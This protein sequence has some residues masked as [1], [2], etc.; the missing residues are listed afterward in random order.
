LA[1]SRLRRGAVIAYHSALELH[2]SAYTEG[3]EVHVIAPGE[4]G[5]LEVAGFS[6]GF[7]KP[8]RAFTRRDGE[9][10]D[11]VTV[12][13]VRVTT[14]ERS[15]ADL[16][17]RYELAGGTE[18][19]FNSLDLVT[20]VDAAALVRRMR[21][22]GNAAAAGALGYWLE[23]EQQRLGVPNTAL[24]QLHAMAPRHAQYALAPS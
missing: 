6:C 14:V 20:R 23:R 24:R 3:Y 5:V 2:G 10:K 9:L 11:G 1:A 21:T 7:I 22:I 13:D 16:L 8:R 19:L 12:V 18:E 17:V 4:P 15:T